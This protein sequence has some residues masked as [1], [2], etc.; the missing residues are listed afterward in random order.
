MNW[1][2]AETSVSLIRSYGNLPGRPWHFKS[3]EQVVLTTSLLTRY[4]PGRDF[5]EGQGFLSDYRGEGS[6][7][8]RDYLPTEIVVPLPQWE[9]RC[10]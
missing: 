9:P 2:P 6:S 7:S 5:E 4:A 1:P 3:G 10:A 8:K